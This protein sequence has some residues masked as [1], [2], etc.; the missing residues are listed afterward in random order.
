MKIQRI[1]LITPPYHSGVVESAGTWLNLG[2]VTIAG[3]LRRAGY[4]V[5]YYDAMS[6][7]HDWPEISA[8][9]LAF[10]PDLV[11]TTAFTASI[12]DAV[13]LLELAKT[14]NPQVITALGNVHPTFCFE[15]LLA[16]A[17]V[18][19]YIV[20]GEGEHTLVLLLACLQAGGDP[21]KVP[22]LAFREGGGVFATPKAALIKDLDA[23]TP[24]WD[25]VEWPLYTY[26]P[27]AGSRLAIVS[28]SRGC[29]QHCSFCSQQ[30]FWQRTWRARTPE[31]FV[32]ELELLHR[33]HGVTVAMVADELPTLDRQRWAGNQSGGHYGQYQ[34]P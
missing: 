34:Y 25:L 3:A 29:R 33:V 8:R 5:D 11:A 31:N 23:L 14:I 19:D 17:G 32:A 4:E 24:A 13:K 10:A 15:E 28:S 21:K 30:L 7:W 1:S 6:H 2:F 16:T 9:L 12:V 18:I 27:Q 20:R 26:R 22:G